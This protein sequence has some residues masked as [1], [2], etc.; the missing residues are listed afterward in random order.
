MLIQDLSQLHETRHRKIWGCNSVR[1]TVR[2][3]G[4]PGVG[5]QHY[6]KNKTGSFRGSGVTTPKLILLLPTPTL[7]RYNYKQAFL[8]TLPVM[9]PHLNSKSAHIASILHICGSILCLSLTCLV[10]LVSAQ[11]WQICMTSFS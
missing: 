4:K 3:A 8:H 5:S 9:F 10:T 7:P 11:P 1:L 6:I 2:L